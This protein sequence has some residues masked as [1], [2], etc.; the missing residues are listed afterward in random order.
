MEDEQNIDSCLKEGSPSELEIDEEMEMD[1]GSAGEEEEEEEV[2]DPGSSPSPEQHMAM[3]HGSSE[4][5]G[6]SGLRFFTIFVG[7]AFECHLF[8]KTKII[9][10]VI[11]FENE[12]KMLIL[13]C[14]TCRYAHV[15]TLPNSL[16]IMRCMLT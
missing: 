3:G 16:S 12:V 15:C 10:F 6:A 7:T 11:G 4:Q 1:E 9:G 2:G 14:C 8:L 5:A 13:H